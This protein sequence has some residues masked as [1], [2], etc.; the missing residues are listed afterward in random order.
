MVRYRL[1]QLATVHKQVRAAER[2]FKCTFSDIDYRAWSAELG[3]VK[4]LYEEKHATFWRRKITDCNGNACRL[5]QTFHEVLGE[6]MGKDTDAHTA[7]EFAAFFKDKVESVHVST[8]STPAYDVPRRSTPT[9]EKWTL[10][11]TDEVL[12]LISSSLCKTCQ[13]DPVPTWLVKNEGTAVTLLLPTSRLN[14]SKL[15]SVHY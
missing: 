13:L 10:V 6:L 7:D 11:T 5:W 2:R 15:W 1:V 8:M 3:K 14:L 4:A 12:K 9:L